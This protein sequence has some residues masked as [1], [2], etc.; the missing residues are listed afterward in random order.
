MLEI[1]NLFIAFEG[2]PIID[3]QSLSF[4]STGLIGIIGK[5]G[6]GK[7]TLLYA[8]TGLLEPQGGAVYFQDKKIDEKMLEKNISFI[9]QNNDLLEALNVKENIISG[10]LYGKQSYHES[11][12]MRYAKQLEIS[13]HLHKHPSQLSVGQ[14]K[15]VALAR[16]LL[17]ASSVVLC[18]EP[19]GALHQEQAHEVMRLL[20]EVARTRLVILVSHDASLLEMYADGLIGMQEGVLKWEKEYRSQAL[21]KI[22]GKEAR[23]HLWPFALKEMLRQK[24]KL[25][26]LLVF[27]CLMISSF[28]LMTSGLNGL[29][30]SIIKSFE[31]SPEKNLITVEQK[32]GT[33]F[34]E[35]PFGMYRA[36]MPESIQLI[37]KTTGQPQIS[38]LPISTTHLTFLKGHLAQAS[39]EI[40]VTRAFYET[41]DDKT[42]LTYRLDQEDSLK[43]VGVIDEG[44]FETQHIYLTKA[45]VNK[46]PQTLSPY[47]CIWEGT[48]SRQALRNLAKSYEVTSTALM[49][50]DSYKSLL[51]IGTC[52][53]YVFMAISLLVSIALIL[54]VYSAIYQERARDYAL[55]I[56]LGAKSSTLRFQTMQ[57]S[58]LAGLA[59]CVMGS[60]FFLVIQGFIN[61]LSS[62]QLH[63][64]FQFLFPQF[65]FPYDGM[66][67]MGGIYIIVMMLTSLVPFHGLSSQKVIN[68][69]REDE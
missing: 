11:E 47:T 51:E 23:C 20:K 68:L 7:T 24:Q 39:D 6:C 44:F 67:L 69:L 34:L 33:P 46:H 15:R 3:H 62:F 13:H 9:K 61:E 29:N 49:K 17:K 2:R 60:S 37:T 35:A 21:M 25:L 27:Q 64:H 50:K 53:A 30:Q 52:V 26:V 38:L 66:I 57:E 43:I 31:Q 10:C 63:Y 8:L 40:N 55:M 5:S 59:M 28:Y 56:S 32:E 36:L 42:S 16:T 58:L 45:F 41:L 12:V 18:D 19:T 48:Q 1:R 54:I 65:L 22:Q 14:R 4:P